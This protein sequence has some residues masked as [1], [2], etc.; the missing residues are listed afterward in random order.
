MQPII[1]ILSDFGC[2]G[3]RYL[4]SFGA[5][6]VNLGIKASPNAF[7]TEI[8]TSVVL[9]KIISSWSKSSSSSSSSSYSWSESSKS[10]PFKL[11]W[12]RA[13]FSRSWSRLPIIRSMLSSI[14]EGP[15]SSARSRMHSR[16][17]SIT[18]LFSSWVKRVWKWGYKI[19]LKN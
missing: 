19:W 9:P 15:N 6:V 14:P 5:T 8:N 16:T 4:L 13:D 18:S 10:L 11:S 17:F 3:L 2:S 7:D 1:I 12:H